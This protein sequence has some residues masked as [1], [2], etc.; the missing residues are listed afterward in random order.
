MNLHLKT[1]GA[2][3][4]SRLF[5]PVSARGD[6]D[7][8]KT[9]DELKKMGAER[10]YLALEERFPFEAGERRTKVLAAI[11]EKIDFYTENGIEPCVW[12]DTLGFGGPHEPYN[13][14][15]S[16][17]YTPIQNIF[18]T[19]EK[20]AFCPLDENFVAMLCDYIEELCRT[21]GLRTLM[22]DDE[23][24][25]SAR[26]SIG[27]ACELHMAEYRRRLGEDIER[28]EIG[29]KAFCGAPNRYRDVWFSLMSDTLTEFC[30]KIRAAV[31]RVDPSIRLGFCSGYSSWDI[32]SADAIELTRILAGNNKPFLRLMGAPYWYANGRFKDMALTTVIESVRHQFS[33]CRDTDIEVFTEL[34]NY[35]RNR[36]HV[37]A[38]Y[39]ECMD[40]AC[41]ASDGMDRLKYH[42]TYVCQSDFDSGYAELHKRNMPLYNEIEKAFSDKP[43]AGVRAYE[44]MRKIKNYDLPTPDNFTYDDGRAVMR[45]SFPLSQRILSPNTIPTVY[46]GEGLCGIALGENA[47]YLPESAFKKGLILDTKAALILKDRGIDTGIKSAKRIPCNFRESFDGRLSQLFDSSYVYELEIDERADVKSRFVGLSM[48]D[49]RAL[50]ASYTYEN[51]SGQRF[52]V[53]AFSAE[54]LRENSLL[55]RSY[56]RGR[57]IAEA[58][59]WLGGKPLEAS[60]IGHPYLYTVQ[61][62]GAAAYINCHP[63]EIYDAKI[64]LA[65]PA[66]SVRFI[67]CTGRQTDDT[68]VIIDNIRAYGFAGIEFE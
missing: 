51:A 42:F 18:G 23:L 20:D 62:E 12:M 61:K 25:L 4:M 10:V 44:E 16:A 6:I 48:F 7:H 49:E 11:K 26:H 36:Y 35:P 8:K 2:Y 9:L 60:C 13:E 34:D 31:D 54:E 28:E 45:T 33:L 65:R 30:K 66:K 56:E 58:V 40:L 37:P 67:G 5:V 38:A 17:T 15:L 19:E 21:S 55:L 46:E 27:C 63:D 41:L 52:L 53:F 24:C 68:T 59:E 32:E 47:K 50:T 43:S 29:K 14:H 3:L 64:T 22:L 1:K 57:Q 39:A